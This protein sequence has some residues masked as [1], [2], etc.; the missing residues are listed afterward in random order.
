L[1]KIE[2]GGEKLE[3]PMTS[4]GLY[5]ADYDDDDDELK[6]RFFSKG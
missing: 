3:K 1:P 6:S 5:W 4:G 2:R